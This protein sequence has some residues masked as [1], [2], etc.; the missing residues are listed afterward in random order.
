MARADYV[1]TGEHDDN[2]VTTINFKFS[3]GDKVTK[4]V[5]Y[6]NF[7]SEI[8]DAAITALKEGLNT[9]T[10][11][12]VESAFKIVKR[13]IAAEEPASITRKIRTK[14]AII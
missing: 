6:G 13:T 3:L 1:N 11:D 12:P 5:T 10:R 7:H 8:K 2:A 14:Q 4:S 9:I